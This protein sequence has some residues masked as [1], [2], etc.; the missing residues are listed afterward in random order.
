M[1]LTA[2]EKVSDG[3]NVPFPVVRSTLSRD[4]HR[5]GLRLHQGLALNTRRGVWGGRHAPPSAW[6]LLLAFVALYQWLLISNFDR[7]LFAPE[8]LDG[9]FNCCTAA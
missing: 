8:S 1:I 5:S 2:Q 9:T 4:D 3:G 7:R 6:L